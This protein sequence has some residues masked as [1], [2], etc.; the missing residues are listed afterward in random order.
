MNR[1]LASILAIT[2]TLATFASAAL[3]ASSPIE[4]Q[5]KMEKEV[6]AKADGKSRI[7]WVE[8]FT[9]PVS[10]DVFKKTLTFRNISDKSVKS[11]GPQANIPAE[12]IYMEGS[13]SG[14]N[15]QFSLDGQSFASPEKL[16]IRLP[17]G[18][19]AKAP[20]EA[21]RAVKWVTNSP[22]KPGEAGTVS[23]K[24]RVR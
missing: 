19:V 21:Y 16:E 23:F 24:M 13:A 20:V 6:I 1:K 10:G 3:A 11:S 14:K 17:N 8:D 9:R 4:I 7:E 2:A 18:A 12:M 5:I 15:V 22:I